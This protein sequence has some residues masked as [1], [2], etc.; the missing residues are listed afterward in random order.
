MSRL[1][2]AVHRALRDLTAAETGHV[3]AGSIGATAVCND[4]RCLA[5]RAGRDTA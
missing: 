1:V 2:A 3:H 4:P 5:R